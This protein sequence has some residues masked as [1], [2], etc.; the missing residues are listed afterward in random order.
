MA[1]PYLYMAAQVHAGLDGI[2]RQRPPPPATEAPYGAG[3]SLL[4]GTLG[5][6]LEA[7]QRDDALH[8]G[9]G[10]PFVEHYLQVKRHEVLRF[11]AAAD[12]D[13]WQRRE[14]FSRF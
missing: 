5:D 1:N 2:Q 14:Y 3:D 7:L 8:A 11:D 6:A 4:P 10:P 9:F 12:K 13:D